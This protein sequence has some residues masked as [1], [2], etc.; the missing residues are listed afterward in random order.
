MESNGT[1]LFVII[2]IGLKVHVKPD[3]HALD[4]HA[5][6]IC[7]DFGLFGSAAVKHRKAQRNCKHNSTAKPVQ[8][9]Q[10]TRVKNQ[11]RVANQTNTRLNVRT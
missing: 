4:C 7:S 1:Y 5:M 3:L 8:R 9:E 11:R 10:G 6:Q 2:F